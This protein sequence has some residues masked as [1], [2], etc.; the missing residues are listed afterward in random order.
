M[1]FGLSNTKDLDPG[2]VGVDVAA[3][4]P[5]PDDILQRR[6][7]GHVPIHTWFADPSRPLEIEI[8][9]GKGTF[10]VQQAPTQPE[11]NF[12]GIEYAHDFYLY[13]A[14][15]IRRAA[16]PN[17][18]M[19]CID[20][21]DFVH[22]RV[23][24]QAASV[25]HLYFADPW[26]KARHH[27]RRMVQDRF[28]QDCLRVLKPGGELRI[29]TDH[30]DYWAW[31]EEHFARWTTPRGPYVRVPFLSPPTARDGEVV[32]TNFERKYRVEGRDFHA[33]TLIAPR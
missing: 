3:I 15:R 22:W 11:T 21:A 7:A 16:I 27:R 8:G 10:L 20:A 6:G 25:V 31:M 1:S 12:L 29:V 33:V 23:P 5:L 32:G 4:P 17:V 28:L 18:R 13:A 30:P 2:R 9:S 24:D 14:D 19:L 26:P